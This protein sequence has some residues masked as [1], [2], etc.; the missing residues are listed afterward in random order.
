MRSFAM[1]EQMDKFI[2]WLDND[3]EIEGEV[4]S[5]DLSLGL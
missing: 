1:R 3:E 2:E 4:I 5:H